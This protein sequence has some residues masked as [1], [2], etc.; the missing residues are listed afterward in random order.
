MSDLFKDTS[1]GRLVNL[2]SRGRY[3]QPDDTVYLARLKESK[4]EASGS[5]SE[6][7]EA[8]KSDPEDLKPNEARHKSRPAV[9]WIEDDSHNPRNWSFGKKLFVTFQI[10][11]LT[12]AV[13]MGSAIYT[14]GIVDIESDF[15]VSQTSALVG[16]TLFVLGYALGPMVWVSRI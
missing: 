16:L 11:L 4:V 13:Y 3:F 10:C 12:T 2:L 14:A 9:D 1:F 5:D 8:D 7:P 6:S 15:H